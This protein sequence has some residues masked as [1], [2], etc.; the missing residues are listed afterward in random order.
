VRIGR[1]VWLGRRTMVL[2][3]VT[4]AA[5]CIVEPGAVARSNV[6]ANTL[7]GGSPATV[8]RENVTWKR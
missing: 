7:V 2:P 3:D 8:L 6:A 5:C 1:H 4:L